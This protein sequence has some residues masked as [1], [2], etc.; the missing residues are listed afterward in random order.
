MSE[1]GST[2][3]TFAPPVLL[4]RLAR[5][6]PAY[7]RHA[8]L[9][10]GGLIVFMLLYLFLAGW[11]AYTAWNFTFGSANHGD[12]AVWSWIIGACAAFL[13]IF[14]LKAIF[15]IRRGEASRLVE[16]TRA[17]QPRL[18]AFLDELADAAGAPRAH[19][20]FLS[21]QVNASVFYDLSVLN[22]FLPSRKNLEIGLGLFN[23]LSLGELRA[24][25]AHEF[26]HF[27]QKSMAVGRWVYIAQQI[28]G[29]LVARR[30]KLDSFLLGLSRFDLRFAWV[31][32]ILQ[33]IVWS[34][35]SLVDTAFR[36]VVILQRALSREMELQAD[37]VAVSLT[38]SDALIH[39][40]HKLQAADDCWDRTVS[41]AG[42]E[43]GRKRPIRDLFAI[44]SQL[45]R[46]MG[47]VL[48][49][50]LYHAVPSLPASP[51]EHR[52]FKA[53]LAQPPQ[54]WLTHPQNHIREA[55]AKR[56]YVHAA[57][58]ERS[59]WTLFDEPQA[60]RERVS[61][62]LI[63]A[64]DTEAVP[65]EESLRALDVT[66]A[67]ES[68]NERYRGI[69][70]GRSIARAARTTQELVDTSATARL[71]S[72]GQ[73]Y[74][75]ALLDEVTQLRTLSRDH[76]MLSAIHDG[77]LQPPGGVIRYGERIVH[78][79]DLASV[80]AE[81]DAQRQRC[82]DLL[83]EHDR[84]CR[85]SHHA[86]AR[87]VGQGWD[88]YLTGL[89]AVLHYAV[90]TEANLRDLQSVLHNVIA[91][92]TAT[93]RLGKEGRGRILAAA[94]DLHNALGVVHDRRDDVDVGAAIAAQLGAQSW[95]DLLGRLGLTSPLDA[96]LGDWLGAIDSWVAHAAIACNRLGSAALDELLTAEAS[97]ASAFSTMASGPAQPAPAAPVVP[98]T[99]ATLPEG[100]ERPKQKRL[101]WLG[102]FQAADGTL[103][104]MARLAVAGSIVAA[105][106]G[107]GGSVGNNTL[108]IYN[109]LGT[110]VEVR[111]NDAQSRVEAGTVARL[112]LSTQNDYK[113][114][115]R[116]PDGRLIESFDASSP[117]RFATLVYD[118]ASAAPL[119]QWTA[120]YGS[121]A[122]V[123]DRKLG[124][125]RWSSTEAD[126]LFE[127]PPRSITTKGGHATRDVLAGMGGLTV[128]RQLDAFESDE[129]RQ[130]AIQVHARWDST[131]LPRTAEWIAMSLGIPSAQTILAARLSE[132]P[133]D[134]LLKRFAQDVSEGA[135]HAEL[136]ARD[137]AAAAAAPQDS[138]L[139][140]LAIRCNADQ[141]LKSEAFV[142]ARARHP[143]NGWLAYAAGYTEL[144]RG[145]WTEGQ[146]ALE[147]AHRLLPPM[148]DH[149]AIDLARALRQQGR[150]DASRLAQLKAS[151]QLLRIQL[152]LEAGS[153]GD[154]AV[155][156]E[157]LELSRGHLSA[158]VDQAKRFS[159]Q[160]GA[161]V[162]RLAAASDGADEP[163]IARAFALPSDQGVDQSTV[164]VSAAL[165]MRR[166]IDAKPFIDAGSRFATP[167]DARR[168][169]SFMA[170][171]NGPG[172]DVVAARRLLSEM[173]FE[174]QIRAYPV[175]LVLL[176]RSTPQDWRVMAQRILFAAER[177][178]FG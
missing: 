170:A 161:R 157:Y 75:T 116:T 38:G 13:A 133:A 25:L 11:F 68:L 167:E 69:Y 105:V 24:V 50:P 134:V 83:S 28:A 78:R 77:R 55:N 118:V 1:A 104:T 43:L 107:F 66:L 166:K 168:M 61:Q 131:R 57:I 127:E 79:K 123:P 102:R 87:A 46:R 155:P 71:S 163:L 124:A 33:I 63:N 30:D 106:L 15:F 84:L 95:S 5:P 103:P 3:Q 54:M 136:C 97:V 19:R 172:R 44:H 64:G 31:G 173:S 122:S 45:L 34:I 150:A 37:L 51:E 32:W 99:Y 145:H 96:N 126:Y 53:D 10:L 148:A 52:L 174:S 151:S 143:Q 98:T 85:S 169:I 139:A 129:A 142:A 20:V 9:A 76:A 4:A 154:Q 115:T 177:P 48:N 35:R 94:E 41:F 152:A 86:A 56:H 58:D 60:L 158:A 138:D 27:A 113:V 23:A 128:D 121:A 17:E 80:I 47:R 22:F 90:H 2:Q 165:A 109:A 101:S 93:R 140:Y 39:A 135:A 82:S 49:D 120:N 110:P 74:P 114:E 67:R 111:V 125:P 7:K 42:M 108:V 162:L 149:I 26:G 130:A 144:E 70:V 91:V 156:T 81:V 72:L 178:Y 171:L 73:L 112:S 16:L 159:P 36:A 59:A 8:W 29:H 6:S 153:D 147:Q 146:A 117:G 21:A 160:S 176:G 164:W 132:T 119:V 12:G 175:A 18:F 89:M 14:M 65:L 62:G 100:S 88:A 137:Q 92:E 40:L 141:A